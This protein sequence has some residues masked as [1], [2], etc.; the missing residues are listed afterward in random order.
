[1][2]MAIGSYVKG[3]INEN[4]Y[5]DSHRRKL[6]K[7]INVGQSFKTRVLEINSKK[8]ILKLTCKPML[9]SDDLNI[10]KSYNDI[11]ESLEYHGTIV[12]ENKFGFTIAFFNGVNGFI[13][14]NDIE[15]SNNT[16]RNNYLVG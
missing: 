3:V 4:N 13:T 5:S 2:V 14:Y 10:I 11:D 9:L 7:F 6:P 8:K 15:Q 1:M 12:A 16:S